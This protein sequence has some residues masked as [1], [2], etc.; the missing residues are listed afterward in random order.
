MLWGD[1]F[2]NFLVRFGKLVLY[3][4]FNFLVLSDIE[5]FRRE[6]YMGFELFFL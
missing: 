4:I 1:V 5:V 3:I 6:E 2:G